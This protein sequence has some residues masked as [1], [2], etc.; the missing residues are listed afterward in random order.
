MLIATI[1]LY[2]LYLECISNFMMKQFVIASQQNVLHLKVQGS[3][4]NIEKFGNI[5]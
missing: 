5:F 4:R 3:N 1:V 2:K